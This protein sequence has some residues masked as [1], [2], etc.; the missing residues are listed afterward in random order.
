V[1]PIITFDATLDIICTVVISYT[2]NC[3]V[4]CKAKGGGSQF[5]RSHR[6]RN[7]TPTFKSRGSYFSAGNMPV[8]VA[9]NAEW[10]MQER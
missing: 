4:L 3:A 7:F 2:E 8:G 10:K 6:L 9:E 1:Q 5:F